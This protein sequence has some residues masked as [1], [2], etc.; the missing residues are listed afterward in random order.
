MSRIVVFNLDESSAGEIH[1]PCSR[2]WAINAGGQTTVDISAA[3]ASNPWLQFGR[4]ALVEHATLPAWC[5]MIDTPW[6]AIP[7][8][9]LSLYNAGYLLKV[10]SL[11]A[12]ATLTGSAGAIAAQL[13][14]LANAT[15]K[16]GIQMGDVDSSGGT[17]T[18]VYDM[19]PVWDLLIE[20]AGRAGM[21]M[22]LR[23]E[24]GTDNHLALYLDFKQRLGIDTGWLLHDGPNAN[25]E[26]TD[27]QVDG[28]IWNRMIGISDQSSKSSRLTTP[29]TGVPDSISTYRL[30]STVQQFS[31]ATSLS[32]LQDNV[33]AALTAPLIGASK[34][35]L[36]LTVKVMESAFP[37]LRLG[38]S[39]MIQAA[40]LW[41]PGGGH[42]WRGTMRITAMA[43]DESDN[44]VS[45]TLKG[46]L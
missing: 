33:N 28:E 6:G 29:P 21:E 20:L 44:T 8:V 36:I 35:H 4:L 25:M 17:R 11:E 27:A 42:G 7:P 2:G 40:N 24:R 31:G 19:R 43:Y 13:L 3:D 26:I 16:L 14:A 38:N 45:M 41:L 22:N 34:P 39:L 30:R 10:R 32:V 37:Y 15:E 46:D 5:G 18:E 9:R 12:A 23:P 1:A